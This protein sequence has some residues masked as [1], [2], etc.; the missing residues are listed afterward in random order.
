MWI[1]IDSDKFYIYI[2]RG[3]TTE[4]IQKYSLK[5]TIKNEILK[6]IQITHMELRRNREMRNRKNRP[7]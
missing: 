1:Q 3:T 4:T 7:N 5:S 2:S 6:I